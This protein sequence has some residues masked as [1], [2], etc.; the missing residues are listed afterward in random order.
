MAHRPRS[1]LK[2][3]VDSSDYPRTDSIAA[4]DCINGVIEAKCCYICSNLIAFIFKYLNA[5]VCGYAKGIY[6]CYS[7]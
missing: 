2:I 1:N 7:N 6:T 5:N 4:W 3:L